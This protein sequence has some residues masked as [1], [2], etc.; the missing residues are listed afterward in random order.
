MISLFIV[1]NND[2]AQ[3]ETEFIFGEDG[4]WIPTDTWKLIELNN[5]SNSVGNHEDHLLYQLYNPL[6]DIYW[7]ADGHNY[8]YRVQAS[9]LSDSHPDDYKWRI[10][11]IELPRMATLKN[12]QTNTYIAVSKANPSHAITTSNSANWQFNFLKISSN[13]NLVVEIRDQETHHT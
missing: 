12:R 8:N 11:C 9:K 6:F 13:G 5:L 1:P 7:D 4:A 10:D 2:L 3:L